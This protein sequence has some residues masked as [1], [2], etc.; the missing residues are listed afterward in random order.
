[1]NMIRNLNDNHRTVVYAAGYFAVTLVGIAVVVALIQI[2][3]HYFG[4]DEVF[5]VSM[6]CLF[7]WIIGMMSWFSAKSRVSDEARLRRDE[8]RFQ[9]EV[10]RKLQELEN[11]R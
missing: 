11:D 2:A 9:R 4:E 10:E 1:M 6:L 7:T 8:A 5:A 3:S